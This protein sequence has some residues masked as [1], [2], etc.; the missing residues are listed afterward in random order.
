M[1]LC[2]ALIMDP[3]TL[4][5]RD[6]A[7]SRMQKDWQQ[8]LNYDSPNHDER[9]QA[10]SGAGA[11]TPGQFIRQFWKSPPAAEHESQESNPGPS[12]DVDPS[13]S[14]SH[15]EPEK[16]VEPEKVP[17]KTIVEEKPVHV[18][19]KLERKNTKRDIAT[20]EESSV[21][22]ESEM[23]E[24]PEVPPEPVLKRPSQKRSGGNVA[25]RPATAKNVAKRP[26]TSQPEPTAESEAGGG[27]EGHPVQK[28]PAAAESADKKDSAGQDDGVFTSANSFPN[29]I[30]SFVDDTGNWQA[31]SSDV[32]FQYKCF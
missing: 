13:G 22:A 14:M 20:A 8:S 17:E 26:A 4:R 23:E 29:A 19:P 10:D 7:L 27:D 6:A 3:S 9:L 15:K 5:I 21:L 1:P 24:A 2:R 31:I 16:P 32:K 28:K 25:K 30:R 18:E 12:G 11:S